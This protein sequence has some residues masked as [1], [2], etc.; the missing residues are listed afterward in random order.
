MATMVVEAGWP[1]GS[2][3][4]G[5]RFGVIDAA[6]QRQRRRRVALAVLLAVAAVAGLVADRVRSPSPRP[7]APAASSPARIVTPEQI[8]TQNPYMGMVCRVASPSACDRIGLAVFLSRPAR[9]TATVAGLAL[10]LNDPTWS[11]TERNGAHAEYRYAGFLESREP[12]ERSS[13]VSFRMDFG[14]G[15]IVITHDQLI[16]EPGWG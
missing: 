9:V 6:R 1:A 12:P 8:F 13:A 2:F 15:N 7:A 4:S 3:P 5:I 10:R 16:V 14:N 11:I